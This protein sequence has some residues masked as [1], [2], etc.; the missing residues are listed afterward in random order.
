[1]EENKCLIPEIGKYDHFFDDG[2]TGPSRHYICKVE[3]ILTPEE[4]KYITVVIPQEDEDEITTLYD[5]YHEQI[6]E[7]HWL[8][9]KE[10]DYIIEISCPVYDDNLLYAIRTKDG[11]WF[12][13]HIQSFW[14]GGRVDVDGEVFSYIKEAYKDSPEFLSKYVE[15]TEENYKKKK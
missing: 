1:M 8:Y 7:Y 5:R 15:A 12:T 2:K 14:Q 13:I 9:A 10:T 3:R 11:G 6:K 4:T